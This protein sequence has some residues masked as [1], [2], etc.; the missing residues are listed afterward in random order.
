M[1]HDKVVLVGLIRMGSFVDKY[2]RKRQNGGN[3]RDIYIS[4]YIN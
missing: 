3:R 2:E 1:I 4:M